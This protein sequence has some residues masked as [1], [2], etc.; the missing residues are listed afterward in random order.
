MS[1]PTP[2]NETTE[3]TALQSVSDRK[4]HAAAFATI[5][6]AVAAISRGEI[7]VVVDDEDRENEGDLIMAAEAATPETIAF[8][9]RYTSG[10]ICTPLT[11][12]RL[13]EL[14]IPLTFEGTR[15]AGATLGSGVVLV[16]DD[17]VEL[18]GILVRIAEFFREESCGQCVPC[19][20]GT[21]RQHEALNRLRANG[22]SPDGD[23]ALLREVGRAMR[24]ASICGL[25]QT[26]WNAIESAIDRLGV[27]NATQGV[28][29]GREN[30]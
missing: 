19:R 21:V 29:D 11:G 1:T 8:F 7:V 15:A 17:S 4:S 30:S 10:V 5:P 28:A 16:L 22:R 3:P 20:V 14:D 12:D 26:A 6:E 23:I 18:P 9:V 13:D 2:D 25:G 24:D 27:F